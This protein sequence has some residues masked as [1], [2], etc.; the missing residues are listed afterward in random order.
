MRVLGELDIT[1]VAVVVV[2][3]LGAYSYRDVMLQK[4]IP[5]DEVNVYISEDCSYLD[6]KFKTAVNSDGLFIVVCNEG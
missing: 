5:K 3:C 6:L 4:L 1:L 2:L